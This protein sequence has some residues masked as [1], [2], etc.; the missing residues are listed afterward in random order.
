MARVQ[1]PADL[2]VPAVCPDGDP[3]T[4]LGPGCG[5]CRY[6]RHCGT[7]GYL[8]RYGCGQVLPVPGDRTFHGVPEVVP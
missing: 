2:S 8:S 4:A 7:L 5:R 3:V 1:Q 6:V